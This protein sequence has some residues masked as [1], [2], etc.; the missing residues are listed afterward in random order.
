MIDRE[1]L[2]ELC[3]KDAPEA[4]PFPRPNS[5]GEISLDGYRFCALPLNHAGPHSFA[6]KPI[7]QKQSDVVL[8][9]AECNTPLTTKVTSTDTGYW[10]EKCC[11]PPS[12]Q[13]TY[14]AK[15][16][17]KSSAAE[18]ATIHSNFNPNYDPWLDEELFK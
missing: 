12:L 2:L 15:P 18:I 7:N 4:E 3:G 14:L 6:S 17:P 8:H 10:C 9:C 13:D 5:C 16:K 11:Y 1:K